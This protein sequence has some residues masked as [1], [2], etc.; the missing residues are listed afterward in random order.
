MM[1]KEEDLSKEGNVCVGAMVTGSSYPF[2]VEC[3]GL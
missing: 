2:W 1:E 3:K